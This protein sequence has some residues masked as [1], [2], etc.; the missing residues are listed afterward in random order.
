MKYK[1]RI[2]TDLDIIQRYLDQCKDGVDSRNLQTISTCIVQIE[3]KVDNIK[4][5]IDLEDQ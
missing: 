5:M 3:N 4:N 2:E 1:D